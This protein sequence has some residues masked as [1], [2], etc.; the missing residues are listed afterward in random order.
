MCQTSPRAAHRHFR[1]ATSLLRRSILQMEEFTDR[2]HCCQRWNGDVSRPS[3]IRLW[4]FAVNP[5]SAPTGSKIASQALPV[6]DDVTDPLY[7]ASY[8]NFVG[9]VKKF[10]DNAITRGLGVVDLSQDPRPAFVIAF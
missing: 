5:R 10:Y 6:S 7:R 9:M 1:Q 8:A 3:R 2:Y 4:E